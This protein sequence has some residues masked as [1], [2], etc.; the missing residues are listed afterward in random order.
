MQ[1]VQGKGRFLR[2]LL[3]WAVGF[4]VL[5][6]CG[7]RAVKVELPGVDQLPVIEEL[8]DPFVM[9]DGGRV[10]SRAD[11][12][13]RR[14]EIKEM[15]L[16]YQY[17]HIPP[18]PK[19]IKVQELSSETV[20]EGAAV[21]RHILLSMGPEEQ[22]KVN[23]GMIIPAGAGSFAVILK[24]DRRIFNVPIAEEIVR[25]GYIVADYA[26]TDLDPDENKVVGPAQAGYP[27]YDWGTLA[28]WAWGGCG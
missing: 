3:I 4:W 17:G 27:D 2:I 20:Y 14:E 8:P 1:D 26:R 9:N 10:Q 16:Y 28:V 19:K 13:K 25:R 23:V 15:I 7:E 11:W 21:K 18:A 6:G 5:G 22:I 24:N 12:E